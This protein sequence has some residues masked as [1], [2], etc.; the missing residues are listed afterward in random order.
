MGRTYTITYCGSMI[1]DYLFDD[2]S[3]DQEFNNVL[4]SCCDKCRKHYT[5]IENNEKSAFVTKL[6][7]VDANHG[8]HFDEVSAVKICNK[9][10]II[11]YVDSYTAKKLLKKMI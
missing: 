7:F 9:P 4:K 1:P 10:G 2:C 8:I 6:G 5:E 11:L 3:T